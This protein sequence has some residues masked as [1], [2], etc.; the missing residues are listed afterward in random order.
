MLRLIR[1][2]KRKYT[3]NKET[4]GKYIRDDEISEETQEENSTHDECDQ[5]SSMSF[6]DWIKTTQHAMKTILKTGRKKL[7]KN[8]DIQHH[9]LV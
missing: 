4:G 9:T 8:A 7:M 1:Q 5:D 3:N 6:D 2:T